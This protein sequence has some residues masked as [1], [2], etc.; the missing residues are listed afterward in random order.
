MT[1]PLS[2]DDYQTLAR[3]RYALRRFQRFSETAAREAG[4]TPAQHQLLLT[5]RGY[6][7]HGPPSVTIVAELLQLKLHSAGEL[8]NRAEANGLINRWADPDDGRRTRL[9]LTAKGEAKLAALSLQH[10]AELQRFRREMNDVL[11]ELD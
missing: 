9:V 6:D 5:V 3:F 11:Q 7:G 4:L 10:R 1:R 8:V 2:D